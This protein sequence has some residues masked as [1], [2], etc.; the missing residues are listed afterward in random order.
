[1]KKQ[2]IYWILIT[3]LP[4]CQLLHSYELSGTQK[5]YQPVTITFDGPQTSENDTNNP[6]LEYRLIVTF[7]TRGQHYTVPGYYAADGKA[8]QSSAHTGN[9]WRVHFTPPTP[10]NWYFEA[11]FRQ[12]NQIAIKEAP[13]AGK[14]VSFNGTKGRFTVEAFDS[15]A[16]GFYSKGLL[17]LDEAHRYFKFKD[18][19][20]YWV[21]GGADSPENFLAYHEFDSTYRHF[22]EA[23]QGEADPKESLHQYEPHLKDWRIGDPTW[24]KDK[25]K[26]IIGAV[27][28][29]ALKGI[30]AIYFLALNING[31]GKDVWPY[32][33]HETLDRF[34][35]S[36][37]DQWNILFDHMEQ[38]GI[39]MHLVLQETENEKLLD[40]GDTGPMRKL[41]LRELM[42][43]FGHHNALV[44]NLG[45]EN[46]PAHFSPDGQTA[47]Q[48]KAMADYL[49]KMDPYQHPVMIHTHSWEEP[50]EDILSPL[51][52]H[53]TIDGLSFQVNEKAHVHKAILKWKAKADS[54]GQPWI[55]TMDEIGQWHTGV[56]PDEVNPN[57]D[58]M[59]HQVLWGSLMAG[60]AGVEWYF[61][62]N[63]PHNDLTCED[64]RSRSRMWEQTA[65]ALSFF[66][67]YLSMELMLPAD[68][69]MATSGAYCL[70]HP[71]KQYAVYLPS[72]FPKSNLLDLAGHTNTFTIQWYNPR[73]GAGLMDG[74]ITAIKGPGPQDIGMPPNQTNL[75]W[76]AFIQSRDE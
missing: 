68:H 36:K 58:T 34:D 70:A 15:L 32:L 73:T 2:S 59:R 25:G 69:L 41:F 28:Y 8:G 37:L 50:K 47:E 44:W 39:L 46:G 42:A 64:W 51:L 62:A 66:H 48:Q 7:T 22:S 4:C 57:H 27:N 76:V 9:K 10:G 16:P 17:L 54:V 23:R 29:L 33:S 72:G 20:T 52:G 40:Q 43:R 53:P 60:A 24:G 19:H 5:Q 31:D 63:Y 74:T 26:G 71:G 18:K 56:M 13:E 35:C 61:G 14:P 1:M 3:F 11:S 65:H 30:N 38:K 49:K 67:Q 55:I 12:G 21:K 6:F 45:E 75:D